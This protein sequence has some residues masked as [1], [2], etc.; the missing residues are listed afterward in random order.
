MWK[1]KIKANKR[2]TWRKL[3]QSKRGGMA[4]KQNC[5]QYPQKNKKRYHIPEVKTE[6]CKKEHSENKK[7][8][9]KLKTWYKFLK[10]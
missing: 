9:S 6:S 10:I 3:K 8:S 7:C 2:A 5:N 4:Q 1:I